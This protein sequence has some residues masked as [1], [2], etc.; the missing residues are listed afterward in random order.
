LTVFCNQRHD[1][2]YS[3]VIGP[4]DEAEIFNGD[5]QEPCPK[6]Q[7]EDT[8]DVVSGR[9]EA[10]A[11]V[12]VLFQGI[13]SGLVAISPKTTPKAVKLSAARELRWS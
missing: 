7:R 3:L 2:A 6:N 10:L 5:H 1:A 9:R 8:K 13:E 12:K 4:Q 11:A